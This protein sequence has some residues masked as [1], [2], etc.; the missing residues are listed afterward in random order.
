M[1]LAKGM[2]VDENNFEFFLPKRFQHLILSLKSLT[3]SESKESPFD[4]IL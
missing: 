2:F 1:C 4:V 3:P